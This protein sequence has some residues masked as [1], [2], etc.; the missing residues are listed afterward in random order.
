MFNLLIN[1]KKNDYGGETQLLT[2]VFAIAGAT[3][4]N[5]TSVLSFGF[6][7]SLTHYIWLLV[8]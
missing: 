8:L 5:S 2:G 6:S 1:K 7:F 3:G 4:S